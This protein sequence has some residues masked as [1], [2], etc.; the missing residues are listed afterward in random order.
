MIWN[1]IFILMAHTHKTNLLFDDWRFYLISSIESASSIRVFCEDTFPSFFF[2]TN[3]KFSQTDVTRYPYSVR[4]GN[5][6]RCSIP[7]SGY[8]ISYITGSLKPRS[9]LFNACDAL[10][11]L[12][13]CESGNSIWDYFSIWNF[14]RLQSIKLIDVES[15]RRDTQQ[16]KRKSLR[17]QEH[18]L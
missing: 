10:F 2:R 9:K 3:N 15:Q 14:Y 1:R 18:V 7:T 12:R 5:W 8:E 11:M 6:S 13:S 4:T 16:F 17:T